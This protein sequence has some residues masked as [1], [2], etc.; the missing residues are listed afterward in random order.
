LGFGATANAYEGLGPTPA[1]SNTTSV[2][3]DKFRDSNNNN[4]DFIAGSIDL[5][6]L[7][8]LPTYTVTFNSNGGSSVNS[9]ENVVEGTAI[10]TPT[11]PTRLNYKFDGWF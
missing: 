1:P 7:P 2:R 11:A 3:R 4:S 10:S 5:S 9:I 8:A 6:Y